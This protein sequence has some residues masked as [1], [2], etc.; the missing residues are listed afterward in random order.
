MKIGLVL[1]GGGVLGVAHVSI[2]RELEKNGIKLNVI[3]GCSS[4]AIIGVLYADG[5]LDEVENFLKDLNEA[6]LFSKRNIKFALPDK[7]FD[8]IR[9]TLEKHLSAKKFYDLK[10]DF[11]CT[12]TDIIQG[13]A[14][15]FSSGDLVDAVMASAAYPGV[16]SAQIIG[17]KVL[18]DGGVTRNLPVGS[19]KSKVDF[20][21][22]S[23]LYKVGHLAELDDKKRMNRLTIALRSIDLMQQELSELEARDCDF[24]FY[25][26]VDVFN[27][28][29]FD[30]FEDIRQ[31]SDEYALS[32]I[33]DLEEKLASTPKDKKGFWSTL[34]GS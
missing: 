13:R 8:L 4:G 26:P 7:I 30:K 16:F 23:S 19:I 17:G 31:I 5:G 27:W 15:N 6:G 14:V 33:K 22:G 29:N 10:M 20:I 34:L 11:H 1:S 21:I 24:M 9:Q 25:P 18:V 32:R 28:Y 2:L 12:A 3:S